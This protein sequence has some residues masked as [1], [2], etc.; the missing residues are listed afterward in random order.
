MEVL[1]LD[2]NCIKNSYK[3]SVLKSFKALFL[4]D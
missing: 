1:K 3:K 2:L 4:F